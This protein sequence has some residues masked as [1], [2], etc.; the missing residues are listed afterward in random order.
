MVYVLHHLLLGS[1]GRGRGDP[2]QESV[3][4]PQH[5]AADRDSRA[6]QLAGALFKPI[7]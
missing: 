5:A 1:L 2:G 6:G 4:D 7:L 3:R